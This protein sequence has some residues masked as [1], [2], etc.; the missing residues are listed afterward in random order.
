M[1]STRIHATA[2][3]FSEYVMLYMLSQTYTVYT[4]H[5]RKFV[6]D[7]RFTVHVSGLVSGE[8]TKRKQNK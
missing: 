8:F 2:L 5:L 3:T 6:R 4:V 7:S 1:L